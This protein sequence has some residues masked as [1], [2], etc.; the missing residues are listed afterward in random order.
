M[1]DND[2]VHCEYCETDMEQSELIDTPDGSQCPVCGA[3]SFHDAQTP[4]WMIEDYAVEAKKHAQNGN[5]E[6]TRKAL[7]DALDAI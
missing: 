2:T 5:R 7:Q 4:L 6:K 3:M 1:T